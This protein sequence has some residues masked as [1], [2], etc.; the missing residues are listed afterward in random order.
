MSQIK[1][2]IINEPKPEKASGTVSVVGGAKL[3]GEVTL[4]G[5]SAFAPDQL[6]AL[7]FNGSED[8]IVRSLGSDGG[9]FAL[10]GLGVEHPTASQ[11][12]SIGGVIG[13]RL[14]E[15]TALELSLPVEEISHVEALVQ[16]LL[17]GAYENPLVKHKRKLSKVS[18]VTHLSVTKSELASAVAVAVAQNLTRDLAVMPAN[19]V[20]PE[21]VAKTA[22]KLAEE[23]DL[24][25]E[26]WD[27]KQLKKD[28]F[29]LIA[30][31]GMGSVRPPRLVKL[32]YSPKKANKHLALVGKGITFDTGG[33]AVKP[34]AGMLGMKYDMTGAATVLNAVAAIAQL[35]LP[36]KVTAY[37]CL[38]E[39]M[40][41]GSAMSLAMYSRRGMVRPSRSQTQMPRVG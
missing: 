12:R 16:G 13:R 31:V 36:I 2:A 38:A 8:Q 7:G 33:L 3:S 26:V 34:L 4:L 24:G 29:G 1:F 32:T 35:K 15:V 20:Y 27:E 18:I 22:L 10:V 39:N 14:I 6:A 21:S 23:N 40:P 25:Y 37:L 28:G 11:W 30:A 17:L 41:S 19:L 5:S 9:A